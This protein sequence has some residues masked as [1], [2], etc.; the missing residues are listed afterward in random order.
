MQV[1]AASLLAVLDQVTEKANWHK[2]LGK[3]R[4][5]GIACW[6]A[7]KSFIAQVAEVTAERDSFHVDR[8]ITVVDCGQVL[9]ANGVRS[10]IEGGIAFGLSAA[11]R[12]AITIKDG[13]V[14]EQNFDSYQLLRMPD[15]PVLDTWLVESHREPGGLGELGVTL[16]APVVAN[17][18]FAAAGKRLKR[19]PFKLD[20]VSL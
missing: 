7:Y 17:A 5:R 8:I 9:N 2:P 15:A 10:Q 14:Q 1:Q 11:M 3:G 16:A 13:A 19:L 12:E 6:R 18:V 20:E 4:G